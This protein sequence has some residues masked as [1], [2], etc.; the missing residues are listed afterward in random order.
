MLV[1]DHYGGWV[2]YIPPANKEERKNH[3]EGVLKEVY[4]K[5]FGR[6]H[7]RRLKHHGE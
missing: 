3:L 7:M 4:G 6:S 2:E 1:P 5:L